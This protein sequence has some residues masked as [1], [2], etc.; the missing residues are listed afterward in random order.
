MDA[1]TA[2]IILCIVSFLAM[3]ATIFKGKALREAFTNRFI[4]VVG[5]NSTLSHDDLKNHYIFIK[6]ETINL[7]KISNMYSIFDNLKKFELFED[8]VNIIIDV[9]KESMNTILDIDLVNATE[10]G[11]QHTLLEQAR[12]R[13]DEYNIRFNTYLQSKIENNKDIEIILNK[14]D[15]WRKK[16]LAATTDSSLEILNYDKAG[17]LYNR[18]YTIFHQYSLCLEIM[19]HSGAASFNRLN[20]TLDNLLNNKNNNK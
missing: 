11:M 4:R 14:V 20:G 6:F 8:Y 1:I 17:S 9:T 2:A 7:D 13:E 19:V 3:F 5:G 18:L 10:S 12:W 15:L 16:E